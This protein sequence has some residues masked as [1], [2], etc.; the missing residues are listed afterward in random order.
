VKAGRVTDEFDYII[1]GAG[2]A[3]CVLANRLSEDPSIKVLLIEAGPNDSSPL[4]HIPK[5]YGKTITDSRLAWHYTTEPEYGRNSGELWVR[6]KV[7]G[8]SS[9]LNGM[10]YVRGQPQDF[11]DWAAS[12][13]KDWGWAQV[14]SAYRA[15]ESHGLGEDEIRGTGGP[16]HID[17]AAPSNPVCD[18]FIQAC[19]AEGIP[20]KE[21]LNRPDQFGVGYAQSTISKGRRWSSAKA[22]LSPAR[23]RSNLRVVTGRLATRLLWEGNHARGVHCRVGNTDAVEIFRCRGEIIL[24]AGAIESP[25]L[26]QLSGV[27]PAALLRELGIPVVA[28][29]PDVGGNMREHWGLMMQHELYGDS[30]NQGL[31]GWR[32]FWNAIKY[33]VARQGPL[34]S[35]AYEVLAFVKSHSGLDRPDGQFH[36]SPFSMN[37][38]GELTELEKI[39]GSQ[40]LIYPMRPESLGEITIRSNSVLD[41]PRIKA[42]YLTHQ[43]DR[44]ASIGLFRLARRIFE[45]SALQAHVVAETVPTKEVVRDDE[46]IDAY[47]RFGHAGYHATGTCR[48]GID[49]RSVVD[50][51]LCVRGVEGLRVMDCSVMPT[52]VS[53][54]TNAP[55]M[56]MAWVASDMILEDFRNWRAQFPDI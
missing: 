56:A 22:F 18:A 19:G 4:I 16:L 12:G 17:A 27:G 33:A 2:S 15:M 5:G 3:G 55:T 47:M 41:P 8:G 37:L 54:N 14:A 48:M 35:C 11:D 32:L 44:E 52:L 28:D 39:P 24:A 36:V 53:G 31:A 9:S 40:C 20:V 21:D 29:S 43:A 1:V 45:H 6:G 10:M 23:S 34:A 49:K 50:G 7:L 13:L 30:H 26:L 42:N 46:I 38:G 25:K 51:R